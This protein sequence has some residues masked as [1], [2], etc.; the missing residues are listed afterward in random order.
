RAPVNGYFLVSHARYTPDPMENGPLVYGLLAGLAIALLHAAYTDI[1]RR[2]IVDWL[3]AGIAL[4]A[5]VFWWACGLSF[6]PDM[7]L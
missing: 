7:A 6:W 5:P 1:L 4:A 2:E 3:N